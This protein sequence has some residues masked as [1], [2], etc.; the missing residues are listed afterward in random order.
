MSRRLMPEAIRGCWYY[1][2]EKF[3][4]KDPVNKPRQV[5][6]FRVDGSFV[7]YQFKDQSRKEIER[8][9]YTFD[10]NF[11][12]LRGRTTETYRV[13][14]KFS[15]R[16]TL[17][18]KKDDHYLMR[19]LVTED[20][21]QTLSA[22][23]QKEIRILPMR[24]AVRS[25]LEGQDLIYDLVYE[26]AGRK[27]IAIGAFFV[28]A[29]DDGRRFIGLTPYV[30]GIAPKTWERIIQDSYLDIFL[31]KPTDVRVVTVRLLSTGES[32]V[33]NYETM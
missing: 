6:T 33:F 5:L 31:G 13:R 14:T 25:E 23:D 28:E 2:S 4:F 15:W 26:P 9:D 11:L 3:D 7:R 22:E 19:G 16:W 12:I 1:V 24:V 10:G 20:V 29:E 8:G 17:E 18:G 32:M 21:F 27:P 30:E